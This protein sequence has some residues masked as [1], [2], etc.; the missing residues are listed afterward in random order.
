MDA[1]RESANPDG[2]V[3]PRPTD[4]PGPLAAALDLLKAE[5]CALSHLDLTSSELMADLGDLATPEVTDTLAWL[6]EHHQVLSR[7]PKA[8]A[9]GLL[10]QAHISP[11]PAKRSGQN[12]QAEAERVFNDWANILLLCQFCHPI[13]D[14]QGLIPRVLVERARTE[15]LR[16]PT[17]Y[18]A[19]RLFIRRSLAYRGNQPDAMQPF[20]T[21]IERAHF[22]LATLH[23]HGDPITVAPFRKADRYFQS[24]ADPVS[25]LIR[26]GDYGGNPDEFYFA[27]GITNVP[28]P[29]PGLYNVVKT[30]NGFDY[31]PASAPGVEDA[32]APD[33]ANGGAG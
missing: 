28:P 18:E 22:E 29:A 32:S 2:R 3:W 17:G 15:V 27:R 4:L 16:T 9:R 13:F 8:T 33:N 5:G 20:R 31:E 25:G 30:P 21:D 7:A 14:N 12:S 11:W 10:E 19:L 23:G 26:Q 6:H 24:T 1:E